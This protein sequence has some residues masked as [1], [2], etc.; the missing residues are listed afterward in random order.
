M[1]LQVVEGWGLSEKPAVPQ[2]SVTHTIIDS[3][4][5]DKSWNPSPSE[6][7]VRA[8]LQLKGASLFEILPN[9]PSATTAAFYG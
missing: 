6:G 5:W 7:Q 9:Q 8:S 1:G 3:D 4:R 2:P